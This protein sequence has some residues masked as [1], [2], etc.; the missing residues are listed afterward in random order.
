MKRNL[1]GILVAL[2]LCLALSGALAAAPSKTTQDLIRP[3]PILTANGAVLTDFVQIPAVLTPAAQ[4]T[5]ADIAALVAGSQPVAAYFPEDTRAQLAALLP[6]ELP[7]ENL[8]MAE[9]ASLS[10][11]E[12]DEAYGDLTLTLSFATA[13]TPEQTLIAMVAYPGAD[14]ALVWLALPAQAADGALQ[15]NLPADV[16]KA[17]GRDLILSVLIG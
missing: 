1:L 10:L 14:G 7:V 4:T 13:F 12:Y 15:L 8:T 9:F 3:Q 16:L 6:P 11:G 2:A 5:L 17:A